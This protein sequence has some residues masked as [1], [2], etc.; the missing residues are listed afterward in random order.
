MQTTLLLP[1]LKHGGI[2]PTAGVLQW[3]A[4]SSSEGIGKE[5]GAVAW[6]CV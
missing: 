6:L 5:G 1:F 2:T 4:V 3:M